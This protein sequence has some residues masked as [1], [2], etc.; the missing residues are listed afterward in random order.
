LKN[1]TDFKKML[2]KDGDFV[3]PQS[4]NKGPIEN[5]KDLIYFNIVIGNIN[6]LLKDH[7]INFSPKDAFIF[8]HSDIDDIVKYLNLLKI[9]L[10]NKFKTELKD[11]LSLVQEINELNFRYERNSKGNFIIQGCECN[12]QKETKIINSVQCKLSKI[13]DT[14]VNYADYIL[15]YLNQ[16][17]IYFSDNQLLE[18]F[19]NYKNTRFALEYNRTSLIALNTSKVLELDIN[20]GSIMID[21]YIMD[22]PT[23]HLYVPYT[24]E[25]D[26]NYPH[27]RI[28][29]VS[30]NFY[31]AKNSDLFY[32]YSN[33]FTYN[34]LDILYYDNYLYV[35]TQNNVTNMPLDNKSYWYKL[36]KVD[37]EVKKR[38]LILYNIGYCSK[39]YHAFGHDIYRSTPVKI[40]SN[41]CMPF[42]YVYNDDLIPDKVEYEKRNIIVKNIDS[43]QNMN[44]KDINKAN[45][46]LN[47]FMYNTN[48]LE[49]LALS[50]I[51]N[52]TNLTGTTRDTFIDVFKDDSNRDIELEKIESNQKCITTSG[53]L[54]LGSTWDI[55]SIN[56]KFQL[57][58]KSEDVIIS[59]DK[60][61]GSRLVNEYLVYGYSTYLFNIPDSTIKFIADAYTEINT[62]TVTNNVTEGWWQNKADTSS[63]VNVST[64]LIDLPSDGKLIKFSDTTIHIRLP[65]YTFNSNEKLDIKIGDNSFTANSN[66]NGSLNGFY[67]INGIANNDVDNLLKNTTYPVT[68]IGNDSHV[69]AKSSITVIAQKKVIQNLKTIIHY[70][71]VSIVI[72][73]E[74][75]GNDPLAFTFLAT[76]DCELSSIDVMFNLKNKY[77]IR[78][79]D[80]SD[81]L[82]PDNVVLKVVQTTAGYP[83]NSKVIGYGAAKVGDNLNNTTPYNIK[84]NNPKIRKNKYYGIY[85]ITNSKVN[86]RN[87]I[88]KPNL[89]N[90]DGYRIEMR[91]A[92]LGE[93]NINKNSAS[94]NDIINEQPYIDGV[95]LN[96]SN[97]NTWSPIQDED[98]Y[99][100]LYKNVY[101]S[102][103]LCSKSISVNSQKTYTDLVLSIKDDIPLE[104]N[105]KYKYKL[106]GS[107]SNVV[108]NSMYRINTGINSFE[109][110]SDLSTSDNKVTPKIYSGNLYLGVL[111]DKGV[112]ITKNLDINSSSYPVQ[113][114]VLIYLDAIEYWNVNNIKIYYSTDVLINLNSWTEIPFIQDGFNG[115]TYQEKVYKSDNV[116][117]NKNFRLKIELYKDL[118]P[119]HRIR[120]SNL[121]L[122]LK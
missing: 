59:Q 69:K 39:E 19:Y 110:L 91:V 17:G 92:K 6:K 108:N 50:N 44:V 15:Q 84:L 10:G 32:G 109:F 51:N 78:L 16:Y 35:C 43:I 87:V 36:R 114:N 93:K 31:Y 82:L 64:E 52:G 95:L 76:E 38:V 20:N 22:I 105:I 60:Y 41:T 58:T 77:G 116:N 121:R 3:T 13:L 48:L 101:N 45:S 40:K 96:S 34:K 94:Y 98:L 47:D 55:Y 118:N 29:T 81:F 24:N 26:E 12:I 67:T 37:N 28:D 117:I 88:T 23:R 72:G 14:G 97:S 9:D 80:N 73:A 122:T 85:F 57:D 53:V 61:S 33:S 89:S 62:T 115:S 7:N 79:P 71:K 2:P 5:R 70:E 49:S 106:N 27:K 107:T 119:Y 4:V 86:A 65:E 1:L 42:A 63:T 104:T 74:D 83:D 100:K 25:I 18:L 120:I 90:Y 8:I 102:S 103:K 30:F 21:G 68:I 66:N 11:N 46:K 99:F 111:N 54:E 56:D 113:K 112:Y 75:G